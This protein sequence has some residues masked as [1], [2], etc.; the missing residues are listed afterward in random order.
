[1]RD[2]SPIS[3]FKG[4][5]NQWWSHAWREGDSPQDH[6][7]WRP[8]RLSICGE[9]LCG[10]QNRCWH[11]P[12]SQGHNVKGGEGGGSGVGGLWDT[13]CSYPYKAME[14]ESTECPALPM[15]S[16]DPLFMIHTSGS[17]GKAKGII[18]ATAG[19]LL[20]ASTT[21]Q[22]GQGAN[23]CGLTWH[24]HARTI[25]THTFCTHTL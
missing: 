12:I 5:D 10:D 21:F 4:G 22:V 1:M 20:Y 23:G 14:A 2:C 11:S 9:G 3:W 18:H 19:Y 8:K 17:T 6:R 13:F 25:Y 7:G 24:T 16:E 15:D